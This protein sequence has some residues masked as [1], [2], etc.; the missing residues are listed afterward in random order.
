MQVDEDEITR[1]YSLNRYKGIL[2]DIDPKDGD[3][4]TY[5]LAANDIE[6]DWTRNPGLAGFNRC[7][8]F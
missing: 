2:I 3:A 4:G 8:R 6:Q 5:Q 7:K 1:L